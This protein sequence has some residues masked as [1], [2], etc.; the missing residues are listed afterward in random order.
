MQKVITKLYKL[1]QITQETKTQVKDEEELLERHLEI[2][3]NWKQ[4]VIEK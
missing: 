1:E 4:E 2:W 3:K